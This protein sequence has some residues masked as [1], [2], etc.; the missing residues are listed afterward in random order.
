[1]RGWTLIFLTYGVILT[2]IVCDGCGVVVIRCAH[3][4]TEKK[5][6]THTPRTN[7]TPHTTHHRHKNNTQ[8]T[9]KTNKIKNLFYPLYI[10]SSPR[11]HTDN[12]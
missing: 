12:Y 3:T 5:H 1:M 7:T 9:N 10:G 4:H 8:H 6:N 11:L 2:K